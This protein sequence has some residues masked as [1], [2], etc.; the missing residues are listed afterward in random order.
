MAQMQKRGSQEGGISP[1]NQGF[2]HTG[3]WDWFTLICFKCGKK[4]HVPTVC[5]DR[6]ERS[7][8]VK[9]DYVIDVQLCT[10]LELFNLELFNNLAMLGENNWA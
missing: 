8:P 6:L 5:S 9:K 4:G 2:G 3:G 1:A 7:M 10:V